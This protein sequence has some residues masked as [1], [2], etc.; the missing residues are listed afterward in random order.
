MRERIKLIGWLSLFWLGFLITARILF[1]I[2]NYS[3]TSTLTIS[4]VGMVMLQG[5]KMDLSITG[6]IMMFCSLI[7]TLSVLKHGK[8]ASFIILVF[9]AIFLLFSSIII[10]VD[11][12]L[13]QHWGF[14]LN[15]TPLFYMGSEAIGSADPKVIIQLGILFILFLGLSGFVFYK[16]LFPV[17]FNLSPASK[18]KSSLL[19][20][21]ITALMFLPI[22]GSLSVAPM[23]ISF[24]YFHKTN[25]F[26]NHAGINVI[27]N[28]LYSLKR[29]ANISYPEDYFDQTA[30]R[31]YFQKLMA[32][33]DSTIKILKNP[34]P[35]VIL[36]ILES[37]TANVIEAL[38]GV[39]GIAPHISQLAKE[40]ILF[41]NFYSSGDRTDKGLVSILSGYPAPPLRS[42]IMYENKVRQLPQLSLKLKNLGYT[43]SFVYGG[44]ADFA[45]FRSFISHGQFTH[46]TTVDD[47]PEEL[48]TSKWGVHDQYIFDQALEELDTTKG[49]FFKTILTLSSHEPF[50]VPGKPI[51]EGITAEA[52]FLNACHYT[53]KC[54]G[55]FIAKSKTKPWWD[56]TLVII[57]ADHGHRHPGNIELKESKRF[58]I[59]LLFLGG[60]IQRD[61]VIH[62]YGGHPDIANTLL[63]Q[64]D[65]PST[66]FTFSKNLLDPAAKSFA[67]YIFNNGYGYIDPTRYIIHDNTG[68]QYLRKEGVT[69]EEDLNFGKAYIQTL[70]SDYN[71]KK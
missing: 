1:L 54:L 3:L 30:T 14:R 42:I 46:L 22:R 9:N 25:M 17:I 63:A 51:M 11:L 55:D 61:T 19:L 31:K 40:G 5:L 43:P 6:Y 45:N 16:R 70:Y 21:L 41:D 47:F 12:E 32:G 36:I 23:S 4:D 27:W 10:I 62:T 37:Y 58:K 53:D 64:L 66:D 29:D 24:V 60:A 8:W 2:Y 59:P 34:K 44:D 39:S 69:K 20:L 18:K 65:S 71:A 33:S 7:L 15:T 13:Y 48:N 35:N 28:F 52:K 57:T 67:V 50:D 56:N 68:K 49:L 26:A 38:G